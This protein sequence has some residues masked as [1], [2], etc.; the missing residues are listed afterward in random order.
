M[1]GHE[2]LALVQSRNELRD[3]VLTAIMAPDST[4]VIAA[5]MDVDAAAVRL[6]RKR[7]AYDKHVREVVRNAGGAR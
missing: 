3:A 6:A 2:M 1:S 5:W 7:R 4:A